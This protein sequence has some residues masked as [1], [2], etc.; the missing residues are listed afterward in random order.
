MKARFFYV[1]CFTLLV[2]FCFAQF[3]A[4]RPSYIQWNEDSTYS[5]IIH[6]SPNRYSVLMQYADYQSAYRS[7]GIRTY[8]NN[9]QLV[10]SALFP[11][12]FVPAGF[13]PVRKNNKLFW[14]GSYRSESSS[15]ILEGYGVL[16][17]DTMATQAVFTFVKTI[18]NLRSSPYFFDQCS[19]LIFRNNRFY[20]AFKDSIGGTNNLRI[21]KL[22]TQFQK[23]D[24]L[25]LTTIA[26]GGPIQLIELGNKIVVSQ[27]TLPAPCAIGPNIS[28]QS[29]MLD[30]L[31]NVQNCQNYSALSSQLINGMNQYVFIF[32]NYSS[33]LRISDTKFMMAGQ[34]MFSYAS[35]AT[36]FPMKN[37]Y[38]AVHC[39]VN[40][41][42][43]LFKTQL[44]LDSTHNG[45]CG[46]SGFMDY[47]NGKII[48]V[49]SVGI[50]FNIPPIW[51]DG[52]KKLL[53]TEMDTLGNI[54]WQK[55][56]WDG[57]IY[58]PTSVLYTDD[59][60]ILIGGHRTDTS[61]TVPPRRWEVFLLKLDAV[62][63]QSLTGWTSTIEDEGFS[64]YPNP[65]SEEIQ[66]HIASKYLPKLMI[67]NCLGQVVH[68]SNLQSDNESIN[69][70]HLSAGVYSAC[71]RTELGFFEKR[72][73]VTAQ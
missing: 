40:D 36:P 18:P 28:L 37:Y 51:T 29:L 50:N 64:L 11:D 54:M 4:I 23:I 47:K 69:I 73:V 43:A 15:Q 56:Y 32:G 49:G 30:T 55:R 59:G 33:G 44:F 65:A 19:N 17:T 31:L 7:A 42:N 3:F 38:N 12:Y 14:S 13:K 72:F 71:I 58:V 2:T 62:G 60:G 45:Y 41:N 26:S 53:I 16:Q 57:K 8:N 25:I 35:A 6:T 70:R 66:I 20:L 1:C 46:G 10:D 63:N 24:S 61:I 27:S 34:K 52:S 48:T 22:S 9:R 21:Y 68:E 67:L 5:T 39:F